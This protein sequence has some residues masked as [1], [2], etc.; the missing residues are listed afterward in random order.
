[1]DLDNSQSKD[2]KLTCVTWSHGYVLPEKTNNMTCSIFCDKNKNMI[3]K[4]VIADSNRSVFCGNMDESPLSNNYIA[5][6]SRKT[7]RVR[8]CPINNFLMF[9]YRRDTEPELQEKEEKDISRKEANINLKKAMGSKK[10]KRRLMEAEK[11]NINL[12]D[13]EKKLKT[14]VIENNL[15]INT[16][17]TLSPIQNEIH[18]LP[19]C[20]R[21]ADSI[22][23]VYKVYDLLSAEIMDSLDGMVSNIMKNDVF[24]LAQDSR[25]S[26]FFFKMLAHIP[27][28]DKMKL[29]LLLFTDSLMKF[30]QEPV[31]AVRS[32]STPLCKFSEPLSKKLSDEF[33]TIGL[34]NLRNRPPSLRDKAICYILVCLLL[35][36]NLKLNVSILSGFL[37]PKDYQRLPIFMKAIGATKEK[38]SQTEFCLKFPLADISTFTGSRR[39]NGGFGKKR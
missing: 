29:K 20:N 33:C 39:K 18:Y 27:K 35:I 28:Q 21:N 24:Q 14:D 13:I 7:N 1:M 16:N 6:R 30:L 36:N 9:P 12:T 32:R 26:Q 22:E 19:P 31:K 4:V 25:L 34:S 37:T 2:L 8:W 5:I 15:T 23:E 10:A 3:K 11:L 17:V 38:N